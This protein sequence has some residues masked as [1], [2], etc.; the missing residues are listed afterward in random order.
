M[1]DS[2]AGNIE[3]LL[4]NVLA[5]LDSIESCLKTPG[6]SVI[7][8]VNKAR[9]DILNAVARHDYYNYSQIESLL[10][11]TFN[12]VGRFYPPLRGWALSPDLAL[13]LRNHVLNKKPNKVIEFG[14]GSSTVVI[15]QALREVGKGSLVSIE[16]SREYAEKTAEML[17]KNS[18]SSWVDIVV[19][20][21]NETECEVRE[22]NEKFKWYD[23]ETLKKAGILDHQYD[24]LFVDGPPGSICKMSRYPALPFLINNI[25]K[26]A[27]IVLDDA[28]RE[29]EVQIA[30][31]W[32]RLYS[33]HH[34]F[35]NLDKGASLFEF[36]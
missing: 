16:S 22:L 33:L 28:R 31:E 4:E 26:D 21:I 12:D 34:V 23:I 13:M 11:L 10:K 9:M 17:A 19:S 27:L 18:L 14:C 6:G 3:L 25:S 1:S 24:F 7:H 36:K 15:A 5:R 20:Q 32:S 30:E 8:H 35:M 2:D 29:D